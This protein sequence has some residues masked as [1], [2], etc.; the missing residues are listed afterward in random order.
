MS[1]R[2]L[3]A[4]QATILRIMRQRGGFWY[5]GCG[6]I[7]DNLSGQIRILKSLEARGL[8]SRDH[9]DDHTARWEVVR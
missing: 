6:W 5:P 9:A 1:D 7:W 8:V 4:S 2:K 3:G